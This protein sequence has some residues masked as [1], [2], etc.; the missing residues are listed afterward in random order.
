MIILI[1]MMTIVFTQGSSLGLSVEKLLGGSPSIIIMVLAMCSAIAGLGDTS[2]TVENGIG[3]YKFFAAPLI[4][5]IKGI[6]R[7]LIAFFGSFLSQI[8]VYG[9][10]FYTTSGFGLLAESNVVGI[11]DKIK[12]INL[13]AY[14][15]D[16]DGKISKDDSNYCEAA[17]S[18]FWKTVDNFISAKGLFSWLGKY[19]I[20]DN[21]FWYLLI[22]F[23]LVKIAFFF[24]NIYGHKTALTLIFACVFFI[25]VILSVKTGGSSLEP[26]EIKVDIA[27]GRDAFDA[28]KISTKVSKF[29]SSV[30]DSVENMT[31]IMKR[32]KEAKDFIS[33]IKEPKE[34]KYMIDSISSVVSEYKPE[35]KVKKAIEA[36]NTIKF[37][38]LGDLF[39]VDNNR[40]IIQNQEKEAELENAIQ[41]GLLGAEVFNYIDETMNGLSSVA[42]KLSTLGQGDNDKEKIMNKRIALKKQMIQKEIVNILNTIEYYSDPTNKYNTEQINKISDYVSS[43]ILSK[44]PSVPKAFISKGQTENNTYK[45]SIGDVLKRQK[46]DATANASNFLKDVLKPQER[47]QQEKYNDLKKKEEEEKIKQ[48]EAEKNESNS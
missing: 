24:F 2:M 12:E 46:K 43:S 30:A 37:K 36:T 6:I 45:E 20:F 18:G 15:R 40:V 34:I 29:A 39:K 23:F 13:H 21:L 38:I 33:N 10:F 41:N 17:E 8:L 14:G 26:N 22:L 19:N 47:K 32:L 9:F 48:Q 5:I 7:L 42:K 3:W 31:G 25:L 11:A 27:D 28:A 4:G 35:A 1:K 44:D 16:A